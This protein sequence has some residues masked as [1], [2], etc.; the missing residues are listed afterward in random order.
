MFAPQKTVSKGG[1][2]IFRETLVEVRLSARD[3][4]DGLSVIEH[5]MPC[6]EAPPLHIHRNEDEVF[7]LLRGTM[8]FEV[9]GAIITAGAGD[10]VMAPKGTPHRF[11]V[12]SEDGAHCLTLMK[13][14]DFET[15]IREVSRPAHPMEIYARAGQTA[16]EMTR[17]MAS[18]SRNHIEVIGPPLAA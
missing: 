6:G 18:L 3:N 11:I 17:L 10:V 13:G 5:R 9:D 8:R 14:G 7:Y 15:V 4:A 1:D 2:L 12:T 16:D